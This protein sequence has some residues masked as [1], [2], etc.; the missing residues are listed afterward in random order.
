MSVLESESAED[1]PRGQHQQAAFGCQE[2]KDLLGQKAAL[3][4]HEAVTGPRAGECV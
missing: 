3:I 2:G 1:T 4:D